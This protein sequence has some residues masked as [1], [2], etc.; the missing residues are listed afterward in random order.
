MNQ[1][2]ATTKKNIEWKYGTNVK[3][4]HKTKR[5]TNKKNEKRKNFLI[6]FLAGVVISVMFCFI[7][8]DDL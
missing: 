2:K 1:L 8:V 3:Y 4:K 5:I 6:K 7:F